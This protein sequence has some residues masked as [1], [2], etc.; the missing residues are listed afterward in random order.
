MGNFV[1]MNNLQNLDFILQNALSG[2]KNLIE[3]TK[4][5]SHLCNLVKTLFEKVNNI[6]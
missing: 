5:N 3:E 6:L 4:K 2:S 1:I